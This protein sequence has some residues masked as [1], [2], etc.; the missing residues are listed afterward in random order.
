MNK[1][2]EGSEQD[3]PIQLYYKERWMEMTQELINTIKVHTWTK[4]ELD[5]IMEFCIDTI[6][7]EDYI[8]N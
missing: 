6:I 3:H 2:H 5:E 7:S 4:S 8:K 1:E